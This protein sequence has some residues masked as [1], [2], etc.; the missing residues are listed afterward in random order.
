[1]KKN[2]YKKLMTIILNILF[3]AI[4]RQEVSTFYNC[5]DLIIYYKGLKP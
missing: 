1:M 4:K 5:M 2:E 3:K